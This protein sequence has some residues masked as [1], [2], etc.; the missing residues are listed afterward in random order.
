MFQLL[1]MVAFAAQAQFIEMNVDITVQGKKLNTIKALAEDGKKQTVVQKIGRDVI[2]IEL[3]PSLQNGDELHMAF[4]V[5]EN[6]KI[7]SAPEIITFDQQE[8]SI[9]VVGA[10]S[11]LELVVLPKIL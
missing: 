6:K 9:D 10:N 11:N 8:A 4:K 1:V 2:T 7:I 3:T 5:M